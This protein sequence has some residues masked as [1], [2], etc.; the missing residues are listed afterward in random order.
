MDSNNQSPVYIVSVF[1][2]LSVVMNVVLIIR[3]SRAKVVEQTGQAT[4]KGV[5]GPSSTNDVLPNP[6]IYEKVDED[7]SYQ[8]L[9]DLSSP[10]LYD[11]L[12]RT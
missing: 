3:I 1:L 9:G 4:N 8:E 5:N 11:G 7:S 6:V 12:D 2:L 10:S